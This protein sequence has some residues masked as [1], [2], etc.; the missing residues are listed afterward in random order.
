MERSQDA[1]ASRPAEPTPA[2]VR[3]ASMS[4]GATRPAGYLAWAMQ[5]VGVGVRGWG[6]EWVGVGAGSVCVCGGGGGGV[7]CHRSVRQGELA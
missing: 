6:W 4:D 2:A 1:T 5:R 7:R 3:R